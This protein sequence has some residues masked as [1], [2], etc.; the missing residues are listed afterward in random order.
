[1]SVPEESENGKAQQQ[2]AGTYIDKHTATKTISHHF[3]IIS[4]EYEYTI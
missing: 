4:W 3:H 1:M 2:K